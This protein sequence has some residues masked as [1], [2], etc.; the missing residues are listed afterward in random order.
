VV[1]PPP[2]EDASPLKPQHLVRELRESMP[3]D[4]LLFVDNGN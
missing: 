4:A 2:S 1:P 3:D